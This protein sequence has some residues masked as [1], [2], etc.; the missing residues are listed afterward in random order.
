M[1]KTVTVSGTTLFRVAA[2]Y[3]GDATQWNRIAHL[4]GIKDPV[5][6]GLVTLKLPDVDPR[7]T[8]GIPS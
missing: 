5:L 3:L 8:G 4:N 2:L 7:L 6:T 1:A